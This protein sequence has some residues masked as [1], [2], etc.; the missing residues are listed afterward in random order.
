MP[1]P[2][3]ALNYSNHRESAGMCAAPKEKRFD[4]AAT[5]LAKHDGKPG[6]FLIPVVKAKAPV[7]EVLQ[8]KSGEI[9]DIHRKKIIPLVNHYS[10]HIWDGD[11][12]TLRSR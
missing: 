12:T 2:D 8:S 7:W 1:L 5:Y 3:A 4:A 9:I 10:F 6:V 11:W